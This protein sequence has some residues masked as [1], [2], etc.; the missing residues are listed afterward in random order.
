MLFNHISNVNKSQSCRKYLFKQSILGI[1]LVSRIIHLKPRHATKRFINVFTFRTNV[2][3]R[4]LIASI[5]VPCE[6]VRAS[7][8]SRVVLTATA[9]LIDCRVKLL[10][11]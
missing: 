1:T 7:T 2:P 10:P 6:R 5:D 3:N 9:E 4:G 11:S 8:A